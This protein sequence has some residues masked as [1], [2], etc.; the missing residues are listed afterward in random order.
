MSFLTPWL[1]STQRRHHHHFNL[2]HLF[3]TGTKPNSIPFPLPF[4]SESNK[5]FLRLFVIGRDHHH[6][7]SLS[8]R[9]GSPKAPV[10]INP[11]LLPS[12]PDRLVFHSKRFVPISS[13]KRD[14][15]SNVRP[16][17]R[18]ND[19]DG[20]NGQV[21]E[22][23]GKEVVEDPNCVK[24]VMGVGISSSSSAISPD[25]SIG[26]DQKPSTPL[27]ED[28]LT[29]PNLLTMSR[30]L[31]TPYI[32]Y[33]VAQHQLG[34]ALILL[35]FAGTTDLLDG[36]IARRTGK[37]TVFGSIADPAA[38]KALMTTMVI[39]LGA[40]GMMPWALVAVI[41]SRDLALVVSAFFVRFRTLEKPRT[42][43]RY[44]DPRL[45]SATVVPTTISKYNTFLQL[46]LVASLVAFH[47]VF[48][49]EEEEEEEE[50]KAWWRKKVDL[51][52]KG[53]MVVVT[54]TTLWS[55]LG[56]LGGAGSKKVLANRLRE[57]TESIKKR[58]KKEA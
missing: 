11:F 3:Q 9:W 49:E 16:S 31:I 56:Y 15:S 8:S 41:L 33:L 10:R 45:P 13:F 27:S 35:C 36:Q 28:I 2:L 50:G 14:L 6:E 23:G 22:E 19:R 18:P 37:Q 20:S 26:T 58:V 39:C 57:R 25:D 48:G 21:G 5:T 52:V 53:L 29:I 17:P 54:V 12:R 51:F 47:F 44:F 7:S 32:G 38:D 43:K 46:A 30:L 24:E 42:L 1:R 34:T 4:Q 40:G 55:G